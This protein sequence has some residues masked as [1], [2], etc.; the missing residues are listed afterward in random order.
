[1]FTSPV[2]DRQ[3]EKQY[4][5]MVRLAEGVVRIAGERSYFLV[6]YKIHLLTPRQKWKE[7]G[8]LF[9]SQGVCFQTW[10]WEVEPWVLTEAF[11][12]CPRKA[13]KALYSSQ[14]RPCR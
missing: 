2:S 11:Q 10:Q 8:M 5:P 1:M 9:C 7:E 12:L 4:P 3:G 13:Q 6:I 14:P